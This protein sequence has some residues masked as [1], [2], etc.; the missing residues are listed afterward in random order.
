MKT[1]SN[2]ALL[3]ITAT[4]SACGSTLEFFPDYSDKSAPTITATISGTTTFRNNTT[5][6]STLPATVTFISDEAATIYYTTNGSDP[7]IAS[8]SITASANTSTSGP[9][10]TIT[11]TILKFFGVDTLSN[12]STIQRTTILSP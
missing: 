9:S 5:H 8:S 7:S 2:A 1:I 3:F 4:L 10:I 11:N 6:V 12:S